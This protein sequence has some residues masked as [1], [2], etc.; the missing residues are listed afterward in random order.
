MTPQL[1]LM[2]FINKRPS[3]YW[4]M[5]YRGWQ[6]GQMENGGEFLPPKVIC[7]VSDREQTCEGVLRTAVRSSSRFAGPDGMYSNGNRMSTSLCGD[8]SNNDGNYR[9]PYAGNNGFERVDSDCFGAGEIRS[10]ILPQ[11]MY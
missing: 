2:D 10:L 7:A 5:G 11:N 8:N 6:A 3:P 4:R 9:L 1:V